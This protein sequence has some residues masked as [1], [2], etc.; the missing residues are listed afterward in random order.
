MRLVI[1]THIKTT[2]FIY[3]NSF[4]PVYLKWTRPSL[5]LDMST[6]ISSGFQSKIQTRIAHNVDPDETAHNEPSHLDLHCLH[7]Y[8]LWC[9]ADR[10]TGFQ[11]FLRS[12]VCLKV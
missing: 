1:Y 10:V 7:K 12:K 4:I 6:D 5:N 3:V 8:L 2:D 11:P 9:K